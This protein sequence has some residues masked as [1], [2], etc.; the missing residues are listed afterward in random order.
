VVAGRGRTERRPPL[1]WAMIAA[2][3]VAIALLLAVLAVPLTA[4][5]EPPPGKVP[6]IARS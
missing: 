5:A 2:M 1:A 6:R 3:A 4:L